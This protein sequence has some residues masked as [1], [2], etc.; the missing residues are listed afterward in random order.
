MAM[1]HLKPIGQLNITRL[2]GVALVCGLFLLLYAGM[3]APAHAEIT[4]TK[5]LPAFQFSAGG[6]LT[7]VVDHIKEVVKDAWQALYMGI[8]SSANY[9][10]AVSAAIVLY[11]AIYGVMFTLGLVQASTGDV[12]MRVIKLAVVATFVSGTSLT[13]YTHYVYGLFREGTD[14][15][16]NVMTG[17]TASV[18]GGEFQV[19]TVKPNGARPSPFDFI[20][21]LIVQ[22]YNWKTFPVMN[23]AVET[24][25]YGPIFPLLFFA[26]SFFMLGG[27][28]RALWVYLVSILATSLLL[29]LGPIFIPCIL[30]QRTSHL[31]QGWINALV[32]FSLQP[33]LLF[34]FLGFFITLIDIAARDM[35]GV[36][37]CYDASRS[38]LGTSIQLNSWQFMCNGVCLSVRV[39]V[40]GFMCGDVPCQC[41]EWGGGTYPLRI[42]SM[43]AFALLGYVTWSFYDFVINIANAFSGAFISLET[44]SSPAKVLSDEIGAGINRGVGAAAAG[45]NWNQVSNAIFDRK[46][47]ADSVASRGSGHSAGSSVHDDVIASQEASAAGIGHRGPQLPQQETQ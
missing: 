33:I 23:A 35:L 15:L 6:I 34:T 5:D 26:G 32:N 30:F 8:V 29:G 44:A 45:G 4:T 39:G 21:A 42:T 37:V 16:I 28:A 43:L 1:T 2:R 19:D 36:D 25:P 20:D 47:I 41:A 31:F 14:D 13:F 18:V 10:N 3:C 11:I 24:P 9:L 40:E 7:P 38:V 22:I 27:V 46:A 17:I 12:F